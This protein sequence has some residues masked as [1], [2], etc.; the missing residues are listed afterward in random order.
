MHASGWIDLIRTVPADLHTSFAVLMQN[1]A[2]INIQNIV[3]MEEQFLVCRG[4]TAG[5][6]DGGMIFFLPYDQIATMAIYKPTKAEVANAWFRNQPFYS[7]E[8]EEAASSVMAEGEAPGM[9]PAAPAPA[10]AGPG[11]VPAP[12]PLAAR[13]SLQPASKPDVAM[14]P[15]K[16]APGP[17]PATTPMA[18]ANLAMPAKAAMI[19]RLRKRQP[20][21]APPAPEQK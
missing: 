13:P 2:E 11:L 3:R 21:G 17:Q 5:S 7:L 20:P 18:M 9:E 14:V 19:E 8:E 1:G 4:R 6:T 10:A 12:G 16:P 15:A